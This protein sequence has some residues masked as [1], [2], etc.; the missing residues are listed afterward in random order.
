MNL[1]ARAARSEVRES[2]SRTGGD[3]ISG[4]NRRDCPGPRRARLRLERWCRFIGSAPPP[5]LPEVGRSLAVRS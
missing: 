5:A 1:R 4:G 2:L 3:E